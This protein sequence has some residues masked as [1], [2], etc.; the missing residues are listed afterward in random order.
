MLERHEGLW[1]L[2]LARVA[3]QDAAAQRAAGPPARGHA[4][5]AGRHITAR[6]LVR[7]R[8]C[9]PPAPHALHSLVLHTARSRWPASSSGWYAFSTPLLRLFHGLGCW[10]AFG[11]GSGYPS[12][13]VVHGVCRLPQERLPTQQCSAPGVP[14]PASSEQVGQCSS[15][16]HD[17][18]RLS[19][20]LGVASVCVSLVCTA[21]HTIC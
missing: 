17:V 16:R 6:E 11:C 1:P 21:V 14:S 12:V 8:C 3:L 4:R 5:G 20:R 18:P 2:E 9:T 13:S 10:S 19:F 7:G 15:R